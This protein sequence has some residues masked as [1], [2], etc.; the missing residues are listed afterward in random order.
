MLIV[1]LKRW[2]KLE[3]KEILNLSIT[4]NEKFIKSALSKSTFKCVC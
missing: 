1:Y 3:I 2:L 4:E